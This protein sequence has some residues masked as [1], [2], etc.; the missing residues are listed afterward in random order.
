MEE[1][2]IM[3]AIPALADVWNAGTLGN[4]FREKTTSLRDI[5]PIPENRL[6]IQIIAGET[7]R[8][9]GEETGALA[10][11]Q[12]QAFPVVETGTHL[13][14]LRDY[15]DPQGVSL[16]SRLHQNV[17]IS[18]MLMAGEG[19][20]LHIGAHGSNVSLRHGCSGG[21][22]QL[23][24]SL[25]PVAGSRVLETHSLYNAKGVSEDYFNPAIKITAKLSLLHQYLTKIN[26][27]ARAADV[28]EILGLQAR[29]VRSPQVVQRC[30][31]GASK[32]K[33]LIEKAFQMYDPAVRACFG[34][35]FSDIDMQYEHLE[36]LF[37]TEK[38][39]ADVI[40]KAQSQQIN[41][42]L[43]GVGPRHGSVDSCEVTRQFLITALGDKTSFWYR[44][45]SDAERFKSFQKHFSGSWA[46]WNENEAPFD[47]VFASDNGFCR[48]ISR[49]LEE[50][51]HNPEKIRQALEEKKVL[52]SSALMAL[53]FQS[54]GV[55]AHG[56]YFQ[57]NFSQQLKEKFGTFLKAQGERDIYANLQKLDESLVLLSLACFVD[58]KQQPL[59]LSEI[60]RTE[61]RK[62]RLAGIPSFPSCMA[63]RQGA[64]TLREYL[65]KTAP[66]YVMA[67]E[68]SV[69]PRLVCPRRNLISLQA[70]VK[71]G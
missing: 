40:A 42:L 64:G 60:Q 38:S 61:H 21:Y 20:P 8:L 32:K 47:D 36:N 63:V 24:K 35:G 58:E 41:G 33:A 57:T 27:T 44:V 18:A 30:Y 34:V 4:Y 23:G 52:P 26:E 29:K 70:M 28:A 1:L 51:D 11:K 62:G 22:F 46:G 65:D 31:D 3:T 71:K 69:P 12:L 10:L 13:V 45:F 66:G 37:K 54:A 59:T 19:Y 67:T 68:K 15:D 16:R 7:A 53:V 6:L 5:K 43:E 48:T 14:F 25:F 2:Q 9:Y 17:L 50:F 39:L 56:G 49:P 55:L